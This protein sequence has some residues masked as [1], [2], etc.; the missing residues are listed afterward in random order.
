[1]LSEQIAV[2]LVSGLAVYVAAG[3]LFALLF[4]VAGVNRIDPVARA[5]TWG[6]RVMI[7]PGSVAAWPLLLKRWLLR[8]TAPAE[9]NAHRK[10]ARGSQ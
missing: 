5:S 1:M 10:A 6:F 3:V 7:F 4:V 2:W 9:S 8:Q